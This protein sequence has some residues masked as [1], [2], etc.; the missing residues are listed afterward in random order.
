MEKKH[1]YG[2]RKHKAVKGLGVA[3]LGTVGVLAGSSLI[4]ANET[5]I[6]EAVQTNR[7]I[8]TTISRVDYND[9]TAEQK[10]RIKSGKIDEQVSWINPDTGNFEW[11]TGFVAVYKHSGSC[12]V[13]PVDPEPEQPLIPT[14]PSLVPN[15]PSP[16]TPTPS[17]QIP[18]VPITPQ[19]EPQIP[20]VPNTP[21]V[22]PQI[23]SVPN[24]PQVEPQVPSVPNTPQVEPQVPSVPIT[25]QVEPQVPSVPITPQVET[26][27]PVPPKVTVTPKPQTPSTVAQT[28]SKITGI[29]A[30]SVQS[31]LPKTGS[32]GSKT[33]A[34]AG[35][36]LL[37][38]GGY[39]LF[40]NRKTG[41]H[42]AIALLVAGGVGV[43]SPVLANSTTFLDLVENVTL[44]LNSRFTYKPATD[45]CWE[46]VGYYPEIASVPAE[47]PTSPNTL[48]SADLKAESQENKGKVTVYYVDE[49]GN[50]IADSKELVNSVVSTTYRTKVTINGVEKVIENTVP[51]EVD[52]DTTA[53][54]VDTILFN[55]ETYEFVTVQGS[56]TG[57]VVAGETEVTYVYRKVTQPVVTREELDPIQ[58]IGKV[59]VH[60]V[61]E[62][63][64]KLA[65]SKELVNA[66]ISTTFRTKVTTDGVEEIKENKVASDATY[67]AAAVKATSL[68]S[69]GETYEFVAVQGSEAGKVV[70]GETEVTYVYRKVT[71]PVVTREELDPI[72]EIGKVT[73]HYVD[74]AGNKLADSKELVNAIISTTF[75]TKVTT[76]GVEEIK[77]NKVASD[78]T[79][80]AAAVKAT[81]LESNGAT[82]EFMAIE[83]NETGKVVA[84]ETNVTYVYRKL[85]QPLVTREELEPIQ[86]IGKVI[87]HYVDEAGNKLAA[88]KE[89]VNAVIS[90]TFRTKL[91]TDGVEETKENK[92]VSDATY[93]AAAVKAAVL[94]YNG[95]TFEFVA[96]KGNETGK[97]VAGETE[98]TYVYRKLVQPLVTREELEPIQEIGKVIVHY[99]DEAGN[100]LAASKELV[101]AVISTTFRTKLTTDGVE[102]MKEN[103]VVSD[104]TY[105]AVAV[106]AAVLEYNGETYE[107]VAVK[108]NET[109]KVVAGDTEVTY[110]YRKLVQPVITRKE[111]EP[112]LETGT[113]NVHFED[114]TGKVLA[115]AKVLVNTIVSLTERTETI[116]DG[117]SNIVETKRETNASYDATNL[118]PDRIEF[119]GALYEFA[120]VTGEVSGKVLPGETNIRYIY[121]KVPN[122][123]EE[124]TREIKGKVVTRYI[125]EV[126]GQE[127][128][129]ESIV[130]E[131]VIALE[132]TTVTKDAL[133]NTVDSQTSSSSAS[134]EY[135]TE[136]DKIVKEVE[137]AK[138]RTKATD[139]INPE[140]Q[141]TGQVENNAA[142]GLLDHLTSRVRIYSPTNPADPDNVAETLDYVRKEGFDEASQKIE[143]IG[144]GNN[145]TIY[146][147]RDYTDYSYSYTRP[148]K[149]LIPEAEYEFSRVEGQE[150][151]NSNQEVKTITYY[152]KPKAVEVKPIIQHIEPEVLPV[153]S[154]KPANTVE[155][156][157][158][159]I[160]G[161][162]ITRYVDESTGQEILTGSTVAEGV[163]AI[164]T[165]T[166]TKDYTGKVVDTQVTTEPTNLQ[167]DTTADRDLNNSRIATMRVTP[168]E[169]LNTLTGQISPIVNGEAAA[170]AETLDVYIPLSNPQLDGRF[171]SNRYAAERGFDI[172]TAQLVESS[173][174]TA[175]REPNEPE[176]YHISNVVTQDGV[177]TP[178]FEISNGQ[179]YYVQHYVYTKPV[180][181]EENPVPYQFTRVDTAE[182]GT[183]EEG[184]TVVTYYYKRVSLSVTPTSNSV[185]IYLSE[186]TLKA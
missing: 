91:I 19:V 138:K 160:T 10:A 72:Q 27:V 181:I 22:E 115:P 6:S 120:T 45:T 50:T 61:D 32:V 11:I 186:T 56:E 1:R 167:Y 68:E 7:T 139:W 143:E 177:V 33:I 108:G 35:L 109:G 106:K 110:V 154:V 111:L 36:G 37:T 148:S 149:A 52:Y 15:L 29:P 127:I 158:R 114:E 3:L 90:T 129:P 99:V 31:I 79:Y 185:G 51:T 24:T 65:D 146:G 13:V 70:A 156:S 101:N 16:N 54:K 171:L 42:V 118:R 124:F 5:S 94:E 132:T 41:K 141:Q 39:L 77:E 119:E 80:N 112:I 97:V 169:A 2:F 102:E 89:L 103:K 93:N 151:G 83:G 140:T 43:S 128:V 121:R 123:T 8:D 75:R 9:L 142:Q 95:E 131:G 183:V 66:I 14:S 182:T 125:D 173:S 26:Q 166:T 116:T 133:G 76:D 107:F 46:Y 12:Q 4:S 64:N 59:T 81:S 74:E 104:A 71:Q 57:K 40:K 96:V 44:Q 23:P 86:E 134:F 113:V 17:P 98:V 92:V 184:V 152:Y 49:N 159:E 55:D 174:V 18:S 161:K 69:N 178:E 28:V 48:T 137:I 136:A 25:P 168:L 126:T 88:S 153:E 145:T 157:K 67:N 84:G 82:Y 78:A 144:S 164:E 87:V 34:I 180:T 130:K 47:T 135:S 60:Y 162:V 165:T 30:K 38:L 117:V 20:S 21:Q 62:A 172:G 73:V 150:V 105:N 100:K 53:L 85:V 155:E 179:V 122:T 163:V 58:E 170:V 175:S 63:G 176:T 147:T